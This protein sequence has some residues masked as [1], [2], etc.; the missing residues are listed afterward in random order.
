MKLQ[1]PLRRWEVIAGICKSIDAKTV[2]EVGC[3][4]GRLTNYLLANIPELTVHAIDPWDRVPKNEGESYDNWNWKE[5]ER[6]F[7]ENTSAYANRCHF[8]QMTSAEG[9]RG[10]GDQTLDLVFIDGAHDY[11]NVMTDISVWWSKIKPSGFL[12]G[13]DYQHKFPGVHRAVADHF[14]L[15]QVA[16]MPDSVWAVSR[17][18]TG[19]KKDV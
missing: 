19:A 5:I 17:N 14:D 16:I 10:F 4:E 8:Y 12:T 9:V 3:K 18:A 7:G 11:E 13:H 1:S 15:M 2:V 6:Q